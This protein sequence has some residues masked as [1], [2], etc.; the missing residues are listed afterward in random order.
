MLLLEV[1]AIT[2]LGT[3]MSIGVLASL[4]LLDTLA[5]MLVEV[6][7]V[8][9]VLAVLAIPFLAAF[10]LFMDWV[11]LA[12]GIV[13]VKFLALGLTVLAIPFLASFSIFMGRVALA[14][15]LVEVELLA[16]GLTVF[17]S[18]FVTSFRVLRLGLRLGML[19]LGTMA[20]APFINPPAFTFRVAA[21]ASV[22]VFALDRFRRFGFMRFGDLGWRGMAITPFIYP[23][24]LS[25]LV[26]ITAFIFV[27]AF[28]GLLF[29]PVVMLGR[30]S[31]WL[32][33][34][35]GVAPIALSFLP[36]VSITEAKWTH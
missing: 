22:V 31:R 18:P 35:L 33:S 20:V 27:V 34:A 19:R 28:P 11:A 10:R 30:R 3:S 2:L 26:T 9:F 25:F 5:R 15:G 29:L 7:A 8:A 13:E 16:L 14:V 17:A 24:A 4:G 21:L 12:V 32:T 6:E 1:V 23:V 36:I